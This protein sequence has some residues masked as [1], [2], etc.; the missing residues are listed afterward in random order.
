[1]KF[2]PQMQLRFRDE[3]QFRKVKESAHR[4]AQS[5]NEWILGKIEDSGGRVEGR[6]KAKPG[7]LPKAGPVADPPEVVQGLGTCKHGFRTHAECG[8]KDGRVSG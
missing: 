7:E 8:Y 5:M 1:M 6:Q 2:R 3:E 4:A